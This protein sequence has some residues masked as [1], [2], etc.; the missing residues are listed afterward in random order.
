M[1]LICCVDL[2]QFID[3]IYLTVDDIVN[4]TCTWQLIPFFIDCSLKY[5]YKI[6]S[7]LKRLLLFIYLFKMC[8]NWQR[9]LF[10]T[11]YPST[12]TSA[13]AHCQ[14]TTAQFGT[15]TANCHCAVTIE[16]RK[17]CAESFLRT[18]LLAFFLL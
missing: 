14:L 7:I 10:T 3:N 9:S 4:F 12:V 6:E 17:L 13:D 5:L 11:P 15:I 2:T 8:D 1:R 16:H 18:S